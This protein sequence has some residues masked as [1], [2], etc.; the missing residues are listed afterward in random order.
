[1]L[2]EK[3]YRILKRG[4]AE[5]ISEAELLKLL[6]GNRPLRLKQGFDPSRPDIHLGHV[7][8]LRKLR[9]FQE[10]GHQVILIVGDWTA[11]IGDPSG[12]S[13]TRT[14]LS[15]E[16]VRCNA[17]T[18]MEQFFKV[19]DK[20]KT[21]VR[22]QS[23]WFAKFC[24]ADVIELTSKFTLAQMMAREDFNKR[25][26]A[27][28]PIAITEL[29][30][31][32]LQAYDSI[33][34][35]A[36]VE[37]GGIDQKFNCL[38][39]RELQRIVGQTPQQILLMPLLVG[40]DGAHKM[41]KSLGNFIGITES[42]SDIYGKVMSL[43]DNLLYGYFELL[44]DVPD[45]EIGDMKTRI[46]QGL[47]NPMV[48]KKKLA[49]EMVRQFHGEE[50]A[51]KAEEYFIRVFQQK[52]APAEIAE[53][54]FPFSR[55]SQD[56]CAASL[57]VIDVLVQANLVKSRSEAKRLLAQG[58]IEIDNSRVTEE[59]VRINDG[60]ILRAG[61]KRFVKIVNADQIGKNSGVRIQKPEEGGDRF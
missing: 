22:W 25:F 38:M 46:Q 34:I 10:L 3:I 59:K 24:L 42:P 36:D 50:A 16:V 48:F 31:P 47:D 4:V 19:I 28:Q 29:L 58:G 55:Y 52:A 13:A 5:I 8:G 60:A 7:V 54:A 40:T 33:M 35:Q 12:Q 26:T 43:P 30:Y 51:G 53:F 56:G 37:F 39:G 20:E 23:E 18:Y 15:A 61:K 1:M 44:T 49:R 27:S 11:Q 45:E 57:S 32:L 17:Q 41:S 6:Q 9:Q 2:D 14:M 21:Q